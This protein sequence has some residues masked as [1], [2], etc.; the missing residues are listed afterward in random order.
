MANFS[1]TRR[2]F[3]E[4]A[5]GTV[6]AAA[7]G[8]AA[9]PVLASSEPTGTVMSVRGPMDAKDLAYLKMGGFAFAKDAWNLRSRDLMVNELNYYKRVGGRSAAG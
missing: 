1:K 3:L 7:L 2:E 8:A 9:S 4:M 6:S 5:A